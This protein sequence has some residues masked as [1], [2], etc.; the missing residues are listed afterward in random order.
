MSRSNG[1]SGGQHEIFS[2][3][4]I[5][6]ALPPR[7]NSC[8]CWPPAPGR[9]GGGE[10]EGRGKNKYTES[11]RGVGK[12]VD[13]VYRGDAPLTR[14]AKPLSSPF[15][16]LI[17][18]TTGFLPFTVNYDHGSRVKLSIDNSSPQ[19]TVTRRNRLIDAICSTRRTNS[20]QL[21]RR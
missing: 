4:K 7:A 14:P 6:T 20:M 3:P 8:H 2:R 17:T 5:I 11:I 10:G 9:G 15:S 1:G 16:F 19:R 12:K 13:T 21:V 18:E